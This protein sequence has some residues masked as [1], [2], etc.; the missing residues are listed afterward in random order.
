MML[1]LGAFISFHRTPPACSLW[2]AVSFVP[3]R[4]LLE[5]L[6]MSDKQYYKLVATFDGPKDAVLQVAF[7]SLGAYVAATGKLPLIWSLRDVESAI[8]YKG[9]DVWNMSTQATVTIDI[10][11]ADLNQ[12]YTTCTWLY[13]TKACRHVLIL[14]RIDGAVLAW[15][16]N[17][18]DGKEVRDEIT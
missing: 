10:P 16:L 3:L 1:T 6:I 14:G 15:D 17:V 5:I 11:D 18:V 7:S 12:A 4:P 2:L 8:G 9:V 13:F